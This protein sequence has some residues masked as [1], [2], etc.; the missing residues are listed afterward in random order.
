MRASHLAVGSI[1]LNVALAVVALTVSRHA[2]L[3]SFATVDEAAL[4][5]KS[6]SLVRTNVVRMEVGVTNAAPDFHWSQVQAEDLER[7]VANLR[8]IGC[9]EDSIRDIIRGALVD[10]FLQRRREL[11][12]P[13]Q[14]DYWNLI[15]QGMD[16]I[17][18][19]TRKEIE[20]L[21]KETIDKADVLVSAKRKAG[22]PNGRHSEIADFLPEDKQ[23]QF[24]ELNDK[25]DQMQ[26]ALS[27]DRSAKGSE[28]A[29]KEKEIQRQRDAAIQTVLTPEE[30]AEY[31]LRNSRFA[32]VG[33]E[34][35]GVEMSADEL[36]A[37]TRTY[38]QFEAAGRSPDRKGAD[39]QAKLAEQK[40]AQRQR[41]EAVKNLLGEERF[42][43]YQ[44]AGDSGYQQIYQVAERYQLPRETVVQADDLRK[45]AI[46]AAK[47]LRQSTG[48][49]NE[50][51]LAALQQIQQETRTA[52]N[53]TLG[54]RATATY[55]EHGGDWLH[56]L[57]ED[58]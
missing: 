44:R 57:D 24:V 26:R 39:Y 51:R 46:E 49:S 31:K 22:K 42:A 41:D 38:E 8:A 20:Q 11:M 3:P 53:Q 34:L 10:V 15:V 12:E 50:E 58:R 13:I 1:L 29:E 33:A 7:Y 21:T 14:K 54:P 35:V 25:F 47:Q 27:Q 37:L 4:R 40:E 43:D 32:N 18:A 5:S 52:L 6:V 56:G 9:P 36:R 2:P 48:L 23:R 17:R 45:A 19:R 28:R 55:Q 30:L 16:A